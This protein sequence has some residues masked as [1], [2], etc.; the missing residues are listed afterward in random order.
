LKPNK[1]SPKRKRERE[2]EKGEG[3]KAFE[4]TKREKA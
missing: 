1:K 2:R 4:R 3:G